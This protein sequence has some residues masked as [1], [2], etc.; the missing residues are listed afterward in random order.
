VK[1][2]IAFSASYDALGAAPTM[3][4]GHEASLSPLLAILYLSKVFSS[5]FKAVPRRFD[6]IFILTPSG[7]LNHDATE[8]FLDY[9]PSNVKSKI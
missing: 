7:S 8:K 2:L 6:L 5:E 4:A 1:P 3:H 9:I